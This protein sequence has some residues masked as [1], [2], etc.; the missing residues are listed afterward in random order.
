MKRAL[1]CT[2]F[3]V[4]AFAL[5]SHTARPAAPATEAQDAPRALV[6][7][8]KSGES[9]AR[10]VEITH[11]LD[12]TSLG[13]GP[14]TGGELRRSTADMRVETKLALALED[15]LLAVGAGRIERLRRRFRTGSFHAEL[16]PK[17]KGAAA[18]KAVYD[19][20]T[21]LAGISVVS[22]WVPE[23]RG[24][25]RHY[26][27]VETLE[28]FLE[29]LHEDVDLRALLP[30]TP[31]SAG[32]AWTIPAK[33]LADVFAPCG[34]LPWSWPKNLDRVMARSFSTGIG[35]GLGE[36]FGGTVAG[37]AKAK[38]ARFETRAGEEL[39]IV[40]LE[41]DLRLE[42]DQ[43][44]VVLDPGSLDENAPPPTAMATRTQW[45][46]RGQGELVWSLSG[47]RARSLRITGDQKVGASVRF[48]ATRQ[49]MDLAGTL[50]V[51][52]GVR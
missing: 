33:E 50:A 45:T 11:T 34:R 25:G 15:E 13:T 26:D 5:V 48:G 32:A 30:A 43:G 36:L 17:A 44:E 46:F 21:P 29:A 2:A 7:A 23:E 42:R 8:P 9:L 3:V 14:A 22:T 24:Y 37:D 4:L 47:A 31:V 49:E 35:G 39:A 51:E 12:L 6:F 38:L 52:Y 10:T 41:F 40:T 19:V 27:E 1:P 28:D 20:T 18:Q 16:G